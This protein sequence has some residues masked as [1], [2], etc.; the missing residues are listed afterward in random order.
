MT[1]IITTEYPHSSEF[2]L[3]VVIGGPTAAGKT[4]LAIEVAQHFKTGIVSADSRQFYR[5]MNIGTAKPSAQEL[6]QARH[7][8]IDSLSI[9]DDYDASRF[10]QDA[11][12]LLDQ[13]FQSNRIMVMTGGSGLFIEAV[14][15]GFDVL[16]GKD[17]TIRKELN[18]KLET[19]GIVA[20]QEELK[21]L[22]P[23]KARTLDMQNP[24]RLI[25]ALEII[26]QQV[27]PTLP[28]AKEPRRFRTLLLGIT[29]SRD[30]LYERINSRVDRMMHEGLLDEVRQL[31]PY[32]ALNP[33]RTVG[34]T[35]LFEHLEGQFDLP[36]A[37]ERIK[38][39]SRNYAKRQ[40]TWFRN[41][42][43]TEWYDPQ[44][45]EKILDRISHSL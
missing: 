32:R 28:V 16:P 26:R 17:D 5:E 21:K 3:L 6:Q 19:D 40:L 36:T 14:L 39:H 7:H 22:D 29:P 18:D 43:S 35:E 2:P 25:R 12:K 10:E 11:L 4:S 23:E 24:K 27:P 42:M 37:V 44:D 41:R 9:H 1:S 33:L 38:Q 30:V 34:Y 45:T 15:Y 13:E 31:W 8:F 20:L